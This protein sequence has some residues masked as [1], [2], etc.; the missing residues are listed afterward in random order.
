MNAR[1]V[2]SSPVPACAVCG[3]CSG[4]CG[5]ADAERADRELA[6]E[7]T[8]WL[9][10]GLEVR[11]LMSAA[12]AAGECDAVLDRVREHLHERLYERLRWERGERRPPG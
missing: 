1:D 4:C 3:G 2:E 8:S 6:G 10:Q 12:V 11:L 9:T 5:W 7:M